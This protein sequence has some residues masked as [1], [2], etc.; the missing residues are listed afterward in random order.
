MLKTG[1]EVPPANP[2]VTV[3]VCCGHEDLYIQKDFNRQAGLLIV[4]LGIALSLY[5]FSRRDPFYAMAALALT[6]LI[7]FLVYFFVGDVTVCYSCHA[8]YRGF[9]KNPLARTIRFEEIGEIR[10]PGR[11]DLAFSEARI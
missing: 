11:L 7:D 6:A 2:M 9:D 4:G 5:F 1:L 8:L 3:C 10:R